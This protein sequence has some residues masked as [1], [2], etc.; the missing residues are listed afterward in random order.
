MI[1]SIFA[2]L[3][4]KTGMTLGLTVWTRVTTTARVS[5]RQF[6]S[7][8]DQASQNYDTHQKRWRDYVAIEYFYVSVTFGKIVFSFL[9]KLRI[10]A[11]NI[12]FLTT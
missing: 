4:L 1:F 7:D 10:L 11:R 2:E 9:L 3:Y 5:L 12:R 8:L 6:W